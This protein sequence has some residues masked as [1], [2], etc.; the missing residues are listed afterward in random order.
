MPDILGKKRAWVQPI[1]PIIHIAFDL[2]RGN[3]REM[4]PDQDL[5]TGTEQTNSPA[6]G[7]APR[8]PRRSGRGHRGR[9]RRRRAKAPRQEQPSAETPQTGKEELPSPTVEVF[10]A[11]E[12]QAETPLQDAGMEPTETP[13]PAPPLQ[14]S[15]P[16]QPAS[17]L[18]IQAAIEQVNDII[19]AL[20]ETLEQMDEVLESLEYFERQ[21]GADEREI[22]SLRRSLRQLQRSREGGQHSHRGHS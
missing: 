6:A 14:Y 22:E 5:Q 10:Q 12:E 3:L 15:K 11:P 17:K 4:A 7:Q 16:A 20:R 9:G 18:S 8:S 2:I 19:S 13:A 1:S 21:G